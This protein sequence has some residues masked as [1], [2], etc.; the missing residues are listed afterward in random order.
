MTDTD[1]TGHNAEFSP[2]TYRVLFEHIQDGVFVIRDA[3]LV[4]VNATFPSL[5]GYTPDELI[6]KPITDVIAPEDREMVLD[7]Y[8]RRLAGDAIEPT[9]Q[10]RLLHKNGHDRLYVLLSVGVVSDGDAA[11]TSVGTVKDITAIH[12]AMEALERAQHEY[13]TLR[14][15]IADM[16]Y[17]TDA[18]GIISDISPACVTALGYR[19]DQMLGRKLEDF[20]VEPKDRERIVTAI[21]ENGGRATHVEAALRHRDGHEVWIST[22]AY[23][24]YDAN[25]QPTGIEGIARDITPRKEMEDE[26]RVLSTHDD[27]TGSFNRRYFIAEVERE[28]DRAKRYG[29]TL[30]LLVFDIDL[31]KNVNDN[32]GHPVGDAVLRQFAELCNDTLRRSDVFAR[33]GGEEF[34][35]LMPETDQAHAMHLCE[36][37][38]KVVAVTRFG[39][40]DNTIRM[41]VSIGATTLRPGD[42]NFGQLYSRADNALYQAKTNGRNCCRFDT[43]ASA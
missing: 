43:S 39:D 12:Q 26:L 4:F 35:A 34:A 23:L 18:A 19:R 28:L 1:S 11:G 5:I 14:N 17:S 7:R 32:Y 3:A 42:N 15:T 30:S 13:Q 9:Y 21:S 2:E 16:F 25:G 36:R 10:F 22:N 29:T 27:L 6:G 40:T 31:F 24:K 20:Y 37:L 38:R 41:T 33:M 8:R